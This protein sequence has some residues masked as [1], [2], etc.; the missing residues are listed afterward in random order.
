MR[1]VYK[2]VYSFPVVVGVGQVINLST[3]IY[4]TGFPPILARQ[5]NAVAISSTFPGAS[6]ADLMLTLVDDF[7]AQL[8]YHYPLYDLMLAPEDAG[9]IPV[10]NSLLRQTCLKNV[11]LGKSFFVSTTQIGYIAETT[12]FTI[13]FYT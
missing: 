9:N 7:D 13:H 1:H 10:Q 12:I 2:E 8:F 3:P 5:V 6:V 11:N 4:F